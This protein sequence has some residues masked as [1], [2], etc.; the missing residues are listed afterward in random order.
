M[1]RL[2]IGIHKGTVNSR[3]FVSIEQKE[4]GS[5]LDSLEDCIDAANFYK[6]NSVAVLRFGYCIYSA[7]AYGPNEEKYLGIIPVHSAPFV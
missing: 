6:K 2:S 7:N 5:S 1:W 4:D 3:D